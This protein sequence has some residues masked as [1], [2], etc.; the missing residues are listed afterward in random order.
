MSNLNQQNQ[1]V[2]HTVGFKDIPYSQSNISTID[3]TP[4]TICFLLFLLGIF[5]IF[6]KCEQHYLNWFEHKK[7]IDKLELELKYNNNK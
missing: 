4:G 6:K 7:E 2:S 1:I 3:P 5:F